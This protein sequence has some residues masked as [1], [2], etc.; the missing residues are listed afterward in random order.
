ML[1]RLSITGI[2]ATDCW[3][4]A[5]AVPQRSLEADVRPRMRFTPTGLKRA[6]F[7]IS[8]FKRRLYYPPDAPK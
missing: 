2:R 8:Y 5:C 6:H 7:E 4:A 1:A 3:G